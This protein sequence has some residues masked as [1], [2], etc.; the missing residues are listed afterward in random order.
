MLLTAQ[1][2]LQPSDFRSLTLPATA[3]PFFLP[4]DG[5][6]LEDLER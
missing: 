4:A 1:D 6:K 2:W 3:S 5:V